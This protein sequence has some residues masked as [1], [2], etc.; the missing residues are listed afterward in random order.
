MSIKYKSINNIYVAEFVK[1]Y[2]K[3][4]SVISPSID[5]LL[6][7][8]IPCWFYCKFNGCIAE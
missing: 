6:I 4:L 1:L 8:F 3:K 7:P 2:K 5:L